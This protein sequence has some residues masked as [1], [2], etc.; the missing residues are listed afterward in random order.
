[1]FGELLAKSFGGKNR[2]QTKTK[3]PTYFF[4][5]VQDLEWLV[6]TNG[7]ISYVKFRWEAQ[8]QT[9]QAR[10]EQQWQWRQLPF[11]RKRYK[12]QT[13]KQLPI[14]QVFSI[15]S[16]KEFYFDQVLDFSNNLNSVSSS[17]SIHQLS[18][19]FSISGKKTHCFIRYVTWNLNYELLNI[20]EVHLN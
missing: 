19:N 18:P 11:V 13:S 8:S 14:M 1:M 20:M 15:E 17:I 3:R 10:L 7:P 2:F 16:L 5:L 4:V 12:V 9:Y 6:A